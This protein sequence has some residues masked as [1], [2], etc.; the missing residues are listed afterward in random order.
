MVYMY[1]NVACT[2]VYRLE[3]SLHKAEQQCASLDEKVARQD[4]ETRALLEKHG[5]VGGSLGNE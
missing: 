4:T 2:P 1:M 5:Q 3:A